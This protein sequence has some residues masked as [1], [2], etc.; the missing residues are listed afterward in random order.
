MQNHRPRQSRGSCQ[1]NGIWHGNTDDSRPALTVRIGITA[2][3]AQ[4]DSRSLSIGT[5]RGNN[6]LHT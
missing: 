5:Y 1:A 4:P 3:S 2:N 6:P